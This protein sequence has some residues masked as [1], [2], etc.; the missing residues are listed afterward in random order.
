MN[1][2]ESLKLKNQYIKIVEGDGNCMF[3]AVCD[4]IYG[5]DDGYQ[6]IRSI[7]IDYIQL[8]KEFF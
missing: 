6:A 5:N 4:Q 2:K 3:R 1:F 7:C 8:E